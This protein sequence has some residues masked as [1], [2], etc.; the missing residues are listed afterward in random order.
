MNDAMERHGSDIPIWI[1]E[2]GPTARS[3]DA[4]TL[5]NASIAG[6]YSLAFLDTMARS[7]IG[8]AIFLA[9]VDHPGKPR[10]ALY[11]LDYRPTHSFKAIQ[12]VLELRGIRQKCTT[13]SADVGCI[14]V[15]GTE[16]VDIL[17]WRLDWHTV[18]M[19]ASTVKNLEA[20]AKSMVEL[21]V[22]STNELPSLVL[23]RYLSNGEAVG[24]AKLPAI[25]PVRITRQA[26]DRAGLESRRMEPFELPYGAYVHLG[27]RYGSDRFSRASP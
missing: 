21:D 22:R 5:N 6:A 15:A 14:A 8:D 3:D 18:R 11:T 7:G 24:K 17:L 4:G 16:G 13:S 27:F 10:P 12:S 2:W 19:G 23:D 25:E 9:A 1:T 26:D 20:A